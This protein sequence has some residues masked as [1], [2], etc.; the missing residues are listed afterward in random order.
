MQLAGSA[1]DKNLFLFNPPLR[2][3]LLTVRELSVPLSTTGMLSLPA[4][5]IFDIEDFI[6][7]QSKGTSCVFDQIEAPLMLGMYSCTLNL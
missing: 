3:A 1:L 5:E 6:K 4:G 2:N 7:A